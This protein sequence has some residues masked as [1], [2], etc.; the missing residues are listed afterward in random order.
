MKKLLPLLMLLMIACSCEDQAA[1]RSTLHKAGYSN[2]QITGYEPFTC[3][4][5]DFSSTGFIAIFFA[6]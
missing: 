2:V 4:D 6:L 1:A 5:S 3:S